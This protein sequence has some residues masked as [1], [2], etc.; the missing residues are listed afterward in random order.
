MFKN[1][2]LDTIEKIIVE[3]ICN[4]LNDAIDRGLHETLFSCY[5][6]RYEKWLQLELVNALRKKNPKWKIETEKKTIQKAD[7]AITSV[8]SVDQ[9][10][11]S[12]KA[13]GSSP[14]DDF[15]AHLKEAFEDLRKNKWNLLVY[16]VAFNNRQMVPS[17]MPDFKFKVQEL[18]K[19]GYFEDFN[20]I[21]IEKGDGTVERGF[22]FLL[23]E[24]VDRKIRARA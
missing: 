6:G 1:R 23:A 22:G 20:I 9:K 16:I 4:I 2:K 11:I 15:R 13:F 18:E 12:L 17:T 14:S 5:L 3:A 24:L 7:L 10:L 21:R 19:C 8:D